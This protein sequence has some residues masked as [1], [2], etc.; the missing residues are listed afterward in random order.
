MTALICAIFFL[1]GAAALIFETL[2]FHQAGLALGNSIWASS[3]VM[4]GFMGGLALGNGVAARV[5]PRMANPIHLYA[6][7]EILIAASGLAL[8]HGL[9]ETTPLVATMLQPILDEPWLQNLLRVGLAFSML[10]V[11]ATA[12]GATL[13][14]LVKVLYGR[15]PHFG[16]V[17]GRLYGW[18]TLGA[19]TGAM[20]GHALMTSW[21]GVRGSAWL[22]ATANLAAAMIAV[23][24]W[25][26]SQS[27]TIASADER[28]RVI[29]TRGRWL[30]VAAALCGAIMLGLEVVWFRLLLLFVHGTSLAFSVMLAVVLAGIGLGGLLGARWSSVRPNADATLPFFVCAAGLVVALTYSGFGRLAGAILQL[31]VTKGSETVVYSVVLMFVPALFSGALFTMLGHAFH[32]ETSGEIRAAGLLSLSNTLGAMLGSLLGGFVLLPMLGVERSLQTLTALNGLTALMIGLGGRSVRSRTMFFACAVLVA[33]VVWLPNGAMDGYLGRVIAPH[34]QR[35]ASL[36]AIREGLTETSILLEQRRFGQPGP[37][38]LLTNSFSMS[39]TGVHARRYMKL[40]VY[41]PVALHPDP[42]RALLISYGVGATAQ[43]LVDTR[44]LESIDIVDTSQDILDLSS[45][46]HSGSSGS[47]RDPLKDPRVEVHVED[48]RHFLA[49]RERS[50]DLITGEPPPP[51]I[52]GISNLYTREYFAAMRARLREGGIVSYWLPVHGLFEDETRAIIRAFCAVFEDC[53]LWNGGMLDWMLI[54]SRGLSKPVSMAHFVR[55]W[56]DPRVAPELRAL[57][58]EEPEQL[59]AL[60]MGDADYLNR[61]TTETLPLDDDHP[62]RLGTRVIGPRTAYPLYRDWLDTQAARE[63]FSTSPWIEALWPAELRAST[64]EYFR[65][66]QLAVDFLAGEP[67]GMDSLLPTL[68]RVLTESTLRTLP[69]WV[70]GT[71]DAAQEQARRA[72]ATGRTNPAIVREQMLG[73][74][75]NRDHS[76]V[77][78]NPPG[79]SA[80]DRDRYL[81]IYALFRTGRAGEAREAL[82]RTPERIRNLEAERF[83]IEKLDASD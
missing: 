72:Q 42:K 13:P 60:F 76:E 20:A 65:W 28:P 39:M 73:A 55:Q 49:T 59:G 16:R 62:G 46:I 30:L 15:D 10:L 17:L 26:A 4:A 3:L 83:L 44:S 75:A 37:F 67:P 8:V 52:A 18:N 22:A 40:F 66:Q 50:Y 34:V 54:G 56:E 7:L 77:A 19:V 35:G 41:W 81:W 25:R 31:D 14:L 47:A 69:L 58:I 63:R 53:S 21:I 6:A 61:S 9:P 70:L 57:G 43:A 33:T 68:D 36:V 2:W 12:M 51:K 5:G 82:L 74:I 24:L 23:G 79:S 64:L 32:H 38:K 45:T 71:T 27:P 80:T 48:G 1:S 78:E 29:S 11:P